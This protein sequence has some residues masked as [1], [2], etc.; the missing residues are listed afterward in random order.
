VGNERM[1][2]R[3]VHGAGRPV[4]VR[5]RDQSLEDR[6]RDLRPELGRAEPVTGSS[7]QRD[8]GSV[9]L[10]TNGATSE[11]RGPTGEFLT[12]AE[13]AELFRLNQETVRN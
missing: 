12:G 8:F 5:S 4:D 13:V 3:S 11:A 9:R 2:G 7:R 10:R 1:A 6:L